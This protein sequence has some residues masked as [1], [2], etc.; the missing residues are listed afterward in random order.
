M[1]SV[2]QGHDVGRWPVMFTD[3]GQQEEGIQ[4]KFGQRPT[5]GL[6]NHR[7][8]ERERPPRKQRGKEGTAMPAAVGWGRA[9][10]RI[11]IK[12]KLLFCGCMHHRGIR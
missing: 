6:E 5:L 4:T 11:Y 3:W 9:G 7:R 10:S 2:S 8:K 12:A 1:S